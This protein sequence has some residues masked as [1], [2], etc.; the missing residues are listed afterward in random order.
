MSYCSCNVFLQQI[1]AP[2]SCITFTINTYFLWNFNKVK[3]FE[4]LKLFLLKFLLFVLLFPECAVIESFEC[5]LLWHFL[6]RVL[7]FGALCLMIFDWVFSASFFVWFNVLRWI[8][9]FVWWFPSRYLLAAFFC[10]LV[11][12]TFLMFSLWFFKNVL[13]S[14]HAFL[15]FEFS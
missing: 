8:V 6:F 5:F 4:S 1:Q 15:F 12:S 13:S 2:I 9:H 3:K 7:W 10:F 11:Y 14:F